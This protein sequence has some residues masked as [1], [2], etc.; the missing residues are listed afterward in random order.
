[1][2]SE[3]TG[4]AT[5][6]L[7]APRSHREVSAG[8]LHPDFS[9]VDVILR[10]EGPSDQTSTRSNI[11]MTTAV[12]LQHLGAAHFGDHLPGFVQDGQPLGLRRV[13]ARQAAS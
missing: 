7:L 3:R 9:T 13:G 11:S 5:P 12:V 8:E 2:R 4:D 6:V 1:M 10:R